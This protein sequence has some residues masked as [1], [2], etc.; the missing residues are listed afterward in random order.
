M[1]KPSTSAGAGTVVK[2]AKNPQ[3]ASKRRKPNRISSAEQ[4]NHIFERD[5][6]KFLSLY[7]AE[8]LP[9][10]ELIHL[11]TTRYSTEGNLQNH[12][13]P[14]GER[15][16][17]NDLALGSPKTAL[18][19]CTF[20]EAFSETPLHAIKDLE[21][22]L[23]SLDLISVSDKDDTDTIHRQG[24]AVDGRRWRIAEGYPASE[25]S[26]IDEL[27]FSQDLLDIFAEIPDPDT[28][29]NAERVRE[30]Y[31]EHAHL[32]LEY[33][34]RVTRLLPRENMAKFVLVALQV[35][36]HRH[37][38]GDDGLLSAVEAF[39]ANR[40]PGF[41]DQTA[42][43]KV[44]V[45]WAELKNIL[46]HQSS[47]TCNTTR[48]RLL[49]EELVRKLD[50]RSCNGTQRMN[51]LVGY[52]LAELM[53][54]IPSTDQRV[55]EFAKVWSQRAWTSRTPVEMSALCRVL[56]KLKSW[57]PPWEIQREYH[58]LYG[59]HLSRA[60]LLSQAE[61]FLRSGLDLYPLGQPKLAVWNYLCELLSVYTKSARWH[62][63][64][65]EL[66]ELIKELLIQ[67][68]LRPTQASQG[69]W[70]RAKCELFGRLKAVR[71]MKDAWSPPLREAGN[72]IELISQLKGVHIG[73]GWPIPLRDFGDYDEFRLSIN[74]FLADY[75][76]TS[77]ELKKSS[78]LL[79]STIGGIYTMRDG[80]IRSIRLAL[81]MRLLSVQSRLEDLEGGLHTAQTLSEEIRKPSDFPLG[82]VA[83]PW[84]VQELLAFANELI[85]AGAIKSAEV[86]LKDLASLDEEVLALLS[87]TLRGYIGRRWEAMKLLCRTDSASDARLPSPEKHLNNDMNRG[88]A[89]WNPED[90]IN[91]APLL[92]PS[93]GS[94]R[95]MER[96]T[97]AS[98]PQAQEGL[99]LIKGMNRAAELDGRTAPALK[100]E[101]EPSP[102][103]ANPIAEPKASKK[104]LSS[105]K[106]S[107]R[108]HRRLSRLKLRLS[109]F[110]SPPN[111]KLVSAISPKVPAPEAIVVPV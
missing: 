27:S 72:Y 63:A 54:L 101:A 90:R 49:V 99:K 34:R 3:S 69:L 64:L 66:L 31:Y 26:N 8:G 67:I 68:S 106:S 96:L 87:G 100:Q 33:I 59:Y 4:D 13:L 2:D 85:R 35:L 44:L 29:P 30:L 41:I 102:Q 53:D 76:I 14:N 104:Q 95:E 77:G 21:N 22:R 23:L 6:L 15:G 28:R 94:A 16:S 20:L 109:H 80:F 46:F 105:L 86:V 36:T 65:R 75:L 51:G 52:T 45:F 97:L 61:R 19:K 74:C 40:P 42:E 5:F 48:S 88:G 103:I 89:E 62:E 25:W 73:G 70:H 38:R 58:L 108:S 107:T 111:S 10:R 81:E 60:G 78:V 18:A 39:L 17:L 84:I 9:L 32:A 55:I 12:W 24:W 91:Q 79:K 57:D 7:G 43:C 98:L 1:T 92:S 71:T 56:A 50:V 47:W 37:Q 82:P 93:I 83:P 110:P 11:A